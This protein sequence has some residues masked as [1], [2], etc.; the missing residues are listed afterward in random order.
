MNKFFKKITSEGK[1]ILNEDVNISNLRLPILLIVFVL[2]IFISFFS[3]SQYV[4]RTSMLKKHT[5]AQ[6][7]GI[8]SLLTSKKIRVAITH[9][10]IW[11]SLKSSP[12]VSEVYISSSS[13]AI[14]SQFYNYE[15][16]S[17][18]PLIPKNLQIIKIKSAPVAGVLD[19]DQITVNLNMSRIHLSI[20][21]VCIVITGLFSIFIFGV[22]RYTR[23]T[24]KHAQAMRGEMDSLSFI[25]NLTGLPNR[26]GLE[27]SLKKANDE[28]NNNGI[29]FTFALVNI[30]NFKIVNDSLG[31]QAGDQVIISMAKK[32]KSIISKNDYLARMG[33]DEFGIVLNGT[34]GRLNLES[35][36]EKLINEISNSVH[37]SGDLMKIEISIGMASAEKI[38]IEIDSIK[39]YAEAALYQAKKE[40]KS[41]YHIFSD[42][43]V[44]NFNERVTIHALM[45]RA[46]KNNEFFMVYQPI[47]DVEKNKITS[48]EALARWRH[49]RR[50]LIMPGVFMPIAEETGMIVEIGAMALQM[51]CKDLIWLDKNTDQKK[52]NVAVNLSINQFKKRELIKK[53]R[54]T[55]SDS[56]IDFNRIQFEVTESTMMDSVQSSSKDLDELMK[57]GFS[58]SIDDFGTGY[59]SLSRLKEVDVK[60]LKIDKS[61]ITD[62]DSDQEN[63]AIVTA[64]VQM[65]HALKIRVVAEGIETKEEA[66]M[67]INLQ[68]DELQGYLI[69]KPVTMDV[70]Q[71]LLIGNGT[72][73]NKY[74]LNSNFT[75]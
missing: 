63:Q 30:D 37:A 55:V 13:G 10:E 33:A 50:G 64:V 51:V 73:K 16:Q 72:M 56:G 44:K 40:G 1:V 7:D 35:I 49:P 59:S 46:I 43:L 74:I 45:R 29:P 52:I 6:V 61:F 34:A 21:S 75:K 68:C 57:M 23:T 26:L 67:V 53:I 14:K 17:I 15:K 11:N 32:I 24:A 36:A 4:E 31:Y 20:L 70:V 22:S 58:L 2:T 65:A 62:I 60:K 8:M 69:S 27:S 28:L 54:D 25:D 5:Q 42:D 18:W 38:D 41:T 19:S 39:A 3:I 66:E 12:D 48:L 9:E 71:S 47:Y